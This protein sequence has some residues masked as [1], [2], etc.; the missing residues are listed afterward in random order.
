MA[1]CSRAPTALVV[2]EA[3]QEGWS[4]SALQPASTT[5]AQTAPTVTTV[6]PVPWGPTLTPACQPPAAAT[7]EDLRARPWP[8]LW[9][10]A[11]W[12]PA[13]LAAFSS[14][15]VTLVAVLGLL[16]L[17]NFSHRLHETLV[18]IATVARV[19]QS[20]L[21]SA[22]LGKHATTSS[23]KTTSTDVPSYGSCDAVGCNAGRDQGAVLLPLPLGD[24]T[25]RPYYVTTDHGQTRVIVLGDT[26]TQPTILLLH[27]LT[28]FSCMWREHTDRLTAA[29]YA[30]IMLDLYGH[31]FS[32]APA[33]LEYEP[34]LFADQ[35]IQVLD[36][37]NVGH[38][39]VVGH[40]VGAL[41]AV[42]VAARYPE[43]VQKLCLMSSCGAPSRPRVTHLPSV[44][45]WVVYGII[46]GWS[47]PVLRRV[48]ASLGG[49][50]LHRIAHAIDVEHAHVIE[51]FLKCRHDG[52]GH[53]DDAPLGPGWCI[54][55]PFG[56]AVLAVRNLVL[57]AGMLLAM[58]CWQHRMLPREQ[59]VLDVLSFFDP[60]GDYTHI[61]AIAGRHV[62]APLLLWGEHDTLVPSTV[63]ESF[64]EAFPK[65]NVLVLPS[66]DHN[67]PLQKPAVVSDL[68]IAHLKAE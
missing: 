37:H 17:W 61:L 14:L 27:G 50:L 23:A 36:H 3:D 40:S 6:A 15:V 59:V 10:R 65:A 38:A 18:R 46:S 41:V 26:I 1:C 11:A 42:S 9:W 24:E 7:H 58:W 8:A 13:S 19:F 53:H 25:H 52:G 4:A 45:G 29:G 33:G 44:V 43:R 2:G 60:L 56:R 63:T 21:A 57:S 67:L 12:L 30:V 16:R 31:G 32:S 35:C 48:V 55:R 20:S 54:N 34:A 22:L 66:C 62:P 47:L 28:S 68:L 5:T 51:A 39:H 49:S 64:K